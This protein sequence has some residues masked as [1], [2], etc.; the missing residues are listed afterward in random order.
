MKIKILFSI[1]IIFLTIHTNV[2]S[3]YVNLSEIKYTLNVKFNKIDLEKIID[4]LEDYRNGE[5]EVLT[6]EMK[7][8]GNIDR[9]IKDGKIYFGNNSYYDSYKKLDYRVRNYD[10]NVDDLFFYKTN[11]PKLNDKFKTYHSLCIYI[12]KEN[13]YNTIVEIGNRDDYKIISSKLL[14]GGV[15]KIYEFIPIE[16]RKGFFI[17]TFDGDEISKITFMLSY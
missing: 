1:L 12:N 4:L 13:L 16:K 10:F 8:I 9:I 15:L 5:T 17:Q 14:N 3:Q 6:L 7:K 11:S 2:N